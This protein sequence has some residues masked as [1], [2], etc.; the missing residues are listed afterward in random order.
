MDLSLGVL[1][2]RWIP[3]SPNFPPLSF[4]VDGANSSLLVH[5][6][7]PSECPEEPRGAYKRGVEKTDIAFCTPPIFS[8]LNPSLLDQWIQYHRALSEKKAHFF[9]YLGV[10][11][12]AELRAVVQN[13]EGAGL[14]TVENTIGVSKYG[15]VFFG[16]QSLLL[17]DCQHRAIRDFK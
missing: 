8:H 2:V 1:H 3:V 11:M 13:L 4:H 6:D 14:I 9:M 5:H 16:A 10:H 7:L 15:S 12:N 17:H